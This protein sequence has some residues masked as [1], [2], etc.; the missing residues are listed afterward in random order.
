[1]SYIFNTQSLNFRYANFKKLLQ[2]FVTDRNKIRRFG[3]MSKGVW[4]RIPSKP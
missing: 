1:M 4:V 2:L 3:K